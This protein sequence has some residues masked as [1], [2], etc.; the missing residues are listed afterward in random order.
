[1]KLPVCHMPLWFLSQSTVTA[2]TPTDTCQ[3]LRMDFLDLDMQQHALI[4]M[5][6]GGQGFDGKGQQPCWQV[7]CWLSDW[8]WVFLSQRGELSACAWCFFYVVAVMYCCQDV[9]LPWNAARHGC[10]FCIIT[11][12]LHCNPAAQC[13]RQWCMFSN[14]C[15]WRKPILNAFLMH[16]D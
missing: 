14:L 1:M 13:L 15:A 6:V 2:A 8:D 10:F 16:C 3:R 9:T 11:L 7:V 4:R 12:L 5:K